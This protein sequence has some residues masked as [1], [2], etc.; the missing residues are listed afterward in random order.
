[1]ERIQTILRNNKTT[2]QRQLNG[3]GRHR[4]SRHRHIPNGL[5]VGGVTMSALFITLC[6]TT[7][8]Q[9]ILWGF[10][11]ITLLLVIATAVTGW[12]AYKQA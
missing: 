4:V 8:T 7:A 5:S 2:P 1:M 10:N 6:I 12:K 3:N 11:G 9:S